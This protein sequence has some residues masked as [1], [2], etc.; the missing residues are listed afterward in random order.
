[1]VE[2]EDPEG[3]SERGREDGIICFGT[4]VDQEV[5]AKNLT[6]KEKD[7]NIKDKVKKDTKKGKAERKKQ[8]K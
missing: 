1:M 5:S 3:N 2:K 8:I 4:I 7:P 6:R